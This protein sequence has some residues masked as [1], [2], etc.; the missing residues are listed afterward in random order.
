MTCDGEP[1]FLQDWQRMEK[2]VNQPLSEEEPLRYDVAIAHLVGLGKYDDEEAFISGDEG[3]ACQMGA[4]A[5]SEVAALRREREELVEA[6]GKVVDRVR[7]DLH[8]YLRLLRVKKLNGKEEFATAFDLT[9]IA[10]GDLVK[11]KRTEEGYE[12]VQ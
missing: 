7:S 1:R 12:W 10:V 8:D 4:A 5:L 6:L 11:L 3:L 2:Q 9:A